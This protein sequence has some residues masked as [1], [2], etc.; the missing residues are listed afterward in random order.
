MVKRLLITLVVV[1]W[2]GIGHTAPP[3]FPNGRFA[4]AR[5][6]ELPFFPFMVGEDA[7][8]SVSVGTTSNGYLVNGA[9]LLESHA[10]R[11]VAE[12]RGRALHHGTREL[13]AALEHTANA[14]YEATGTQLWVG[15]LSYAGGGNIEYSVSHNSGRDADVAYCY[16]DRAG[17]RVDPVDYVRVYG[18]TSHDGE[19]RIDIERMWI[20]TKALLTNPHAQVQ[21]MFVSPD[22]E[23]QILEH[24]LAIR[25]P[26]LLRVKAEETLHQAHTPHNDHMHVRLYCTSR[27][28]AGGCEDTGV[29]HP[30]IDT[31]ESARQERL[32]HATGGLVDADPDNRRRALLRLLLLQ[33]H[34]HRRAIRTALRD[35]SPIV[36]RATALAVGALG[37]EALSPWLRATYHTEADTT[38]KQAIIDGVADLGGYEGAVFIRNVI[39]ALDDNVLLPA[40]VEASERLRRLEPV[41][42]LVKTLRSDDAQLRRRAAHALRMITAHDVGVDWTSDDAATRQHGVARWTAWTERYKGWQRSKWLT[43]A[44]QRAG[45]Q[46]QH[47][48]RQSGWELVRALDG[49]HHRAINAQLQLERLFKHDTPKGVSNMCQHWRDWLTNN[50]RYFDDLPVVPRRVCR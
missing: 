16:R 49:P 39:S 1:L 31:F 8:A 7:T 19:L 43:A 41:P 34:Q 12:H 2:P 37:D 21:Y 42:A 26:L 29:V 46:V 5:P 40:A 50:R 27:D 18:T 11:I 23:Q 13:V 32:A 33:P 38:V 10:L 17:A 24:A 47:L 20:V 6:A 36:R 30:W 4:S 28:V 44:F 9:P 48:V 22:I 25:E 35:P 45:Y 14:L 15:N 3:L